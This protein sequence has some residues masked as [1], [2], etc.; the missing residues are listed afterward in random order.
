MS[1]S[2]IVILHEMIKEEAKVALENDNGKFFVVLEEPQQ[3]DCSVRIHNM[4]ALDE[5]I[6]IKAD[7]FKAPNTI[8][9]GTKSE[10]KRADFVIVADTGNKK[11]ILCIEMKINKGEKI[12]EQLKGAQCF[13]AYCREIGRLFWKEQHFLEGY[14]YRFISICQINI[15]KKRTRPQELSGF[16]DS[17][18]Q[19]LKI[20]SPNY[21]QFNQLA[22]TGK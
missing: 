15:P 18:E 5:V 16:G 13:V 19:M 14:K 2:D 12:I 3:P 21:I 6:V 9:T 4:P 7:A 11:I 22:G 8:F 17:P 20:T 1:M 10:C